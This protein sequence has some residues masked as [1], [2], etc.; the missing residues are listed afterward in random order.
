MYPVEKA[1]GEHKARMEGSAPSSALAILVAVLCFL[2]PMANYVWLLVRR[3]VIVAALR[4]ELPQRPMM[5]PDATDIHLG[6]Y[7]QAPQ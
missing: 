2:M 7:G 3:G 6:G 5:M 1:I 4:G